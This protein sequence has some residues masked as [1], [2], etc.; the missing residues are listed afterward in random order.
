MK[1][2]IS[3]NYVSI[4]TGDNIYQKRRDFL[5][6]FWKKEDKE[7]F[8]TFKELTK[9]VKKTDYDKINEISKKNNLNVNKELSACLKSKDINELNKKKEDILSKIDKLP[10]D[11][12]KEIKESILNVS[13]TRFGV[14][15]ET[16]V[17]KIYQ[18]QTEKS[19]VKDDKYRT[20][21]ISK[22]DKYSVYIGGKVDGIDVNN[23]DVIEIKNRMHKLFFNLRS[24]EMVQLM[25]YLHIFE[26]KEGF[27]I[28][29]LKKKD[30]T[31]VNV[32]NMKYDETIM[33]EILE[34]INKFVTFYY[35]FINDYDK[36]VRLLT[37]EDEIDFF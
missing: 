11:Q 27:L 2:T 28:E 23:G 12:K 3:A 4:I 37:C 35:D 20:K 6:N 9:F 31:D 34:K 32:I 17:L 25:C 21:L 8:N 22:N 30:S 1:L 13:N 18:D 15:N 24:Y 26:A 16:N 36:K 19:I 33:N 29:A 7:D 14:K 5:I 10:E